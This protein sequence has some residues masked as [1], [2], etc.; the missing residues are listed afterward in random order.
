MSALSTSA[1]RAISARVQASSSCEALPLA[2]MPKRCAFSANSGEATTARMSA[3]SY[4]STGVGMPA[5]PYIALIAATLNE[6]WE[7]G[8]PCM[9]R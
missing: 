9:L 2:R 3:E 7:Q 6:L 4:S 1:Q 5:G 8:Q